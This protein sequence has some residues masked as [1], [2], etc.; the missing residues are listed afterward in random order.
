[1]TPREDR[2]CMVCGASLAG[3]RP[4]AQV[5]S[6]TCRTVREA[7]RRGYRSDPGSVSLDKTAATHLALRTVGN[8]L[9]AAVSHS[10]L[11]GWHVRVNIG[12]D[13]LVLTNDEDLAWLLLD[14]AR[15]LDAQEAA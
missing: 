3:R 12:S 8:G 13:R 11:Q 4:Y 15:D 2:A 9:P 7:Q 5:C 6:R 14:L 10:R 1:M